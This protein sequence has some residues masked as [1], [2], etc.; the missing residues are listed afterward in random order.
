M[1]R[2]ILASAS[3]RRRELLGILYPSFEVI[4]SGADE[5]VTAQEPAALVEE[6]SRLK[7]TDI[8]EKQDHKED[9]L[10]IGADTVVAFE[11]EILGKPQGSQHAFRMLEKLQG[12][13]HQVYTGVTL[14][15]LQAGQP[16]IRTF[17]ECTEV[18]FYTLTPEEIWEYIESGEPMDKAGS[19]AIQG[20]FAKYVKG[21]RGDYYN[22]VG[23]PVSRLNQELKKM[24]AE[25]Y[26]KG[27][28]L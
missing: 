16:M 9:A 8:F 24:R 14:C 15:T 23:L 3:P 17:H 25:I 4:P 10:V 20:A 7:A 2:I 21:I 13:T 1:S 5:N 26:E 22:V 11:G 27:S 12:N 28:N 18:T 19:Y 6:L